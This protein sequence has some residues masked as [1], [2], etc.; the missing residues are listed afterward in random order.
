[1]HVS[2]YKLWLLFH[3]AISHAQRSSSSC[4]LQGKHQISST[5]HSPTGGNKRKPASASCRKN[6]SYRSGSKVNHEPSS[7]ASCHNRSRLL[8]STY[9]PKQTLSTP[10]GGRGVRGSGGRTGLTTESGTVDTTSKHGGQLPA[11][12]G[13]RSHRQPSKNGVSDLVVTSARIVSFLLRIFRSL[14]LD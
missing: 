1:M 13:S 4:Q 5:R 7:P 3:F 11:Q 10:S 6:S 2:H 9:Y 12:S 14:V 8:S